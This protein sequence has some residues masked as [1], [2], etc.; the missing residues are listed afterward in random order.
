LAVGDTAF[1]ES[2]RQ[3]I[4]PTNGAAQVTPVADYLAALGELT[5]RPADAIIGHAQGLAG[6]EQAAAQALQQLAP[7]A[8]RLVVT[9][10]HANG[11]ADWL[12]QLG[13]DQCLAQ[14][15]N[16]QTLAAA[17]NLAPPKPAPDQP[18]EAS[19]R[20]SD[21]PHHAEQSPAPTAPNDAPDDAPSATAEADQLGDL[22]LID[23]I[24]LEA[25]ELPERA[26][27][28]VRQHASLIE[29]GWV[30][31]EHDV[32]PA[33]AAAPIVGGGQTFAYLHAQNTEDQI[34]PWARWLGHWLALDQRLRSFHELAMRD[35]LTGV[36]NRRYFDR[37]LHRVLPEAQRQRSQ[38]TLLVFDIDDF[39]LYND[40]FGHPAGD[41]ILI[42]V[43]QL[44]QSL[45]REHDV[46]ARIGGDE[47]AVIFW[48]AEDP[49]QP[50]SRHPQDV[51]EVARRFQQAVCQ[52]R[53]PKLLEKAADTL[54]ISGGLASFPWDGRAADELLA[55]ADNNALASKRQG[56][57]VITF[58]PGACETNAPDQADTSRDQTTE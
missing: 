45:V 29:P 9:D 36:W 5:H 10:A 50:N 3:T 38:V 44:M 1:T 49:R 11:Y 6:I 48:E 39:K 31:T 43:G 54:T 42:S 35:D 51:L 22:D 28:A 34:E 37:F 16:A 15:L 53:F 4:A 32:P 8:R 24:L 17:L 46:V 23:A 47:F 27:R 14:P 58:G 21:Q 40:Q 33:H 18:L 19:T 57:N 30:Q 25:G 7:D 13:F 12:K 55:A 26:M 41:E 56:K 20:P 52:H 2:V